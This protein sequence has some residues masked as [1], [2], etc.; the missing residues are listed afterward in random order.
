[1]TTPADLPLDL[2]PDPRDRK[3]IPASEAVCAL[4]REVLGRI[5]REVADLQTLALRDA[6]LEPA[7]GWRYDA[8]KGVF[9]HVSPSAP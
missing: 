7:D 4:T 6:G 5:T 2:G 8:T 3:T 9:V 1:M